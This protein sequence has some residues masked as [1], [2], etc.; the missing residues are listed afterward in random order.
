MLKG[1]IGKVMLQGS[2]LEIGE[3]KRT[4]KETLRFQDLGN[5]IILLGHGLEYYPL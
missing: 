4:Q 5:N 2:S 1:S 3:I